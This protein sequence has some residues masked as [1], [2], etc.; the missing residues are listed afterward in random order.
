MRITGLTLAA[1]IAALASTA[2]A[3]VPFQQ[4]A[5][6][7]RGGSPI[8]VNA[9][10]VIVGAVRAADDS[11]SVPVVWDSPTAAPVALPTVNGGSASAINSNGQIVGSEN[12]PVGAG[13]KPKTAVAQGTHSVLE[14][15]PE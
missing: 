3:D 6:F 8:D 10:G 2:F 5:D 11:M 13:S 7:G 14:K 9:Q 12:F 1:A 15:S 4:L